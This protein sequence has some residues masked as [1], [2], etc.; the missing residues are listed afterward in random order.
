MRLRAG[1][2]HPRVGQIF[3]TGR[4]VQD[5]LPVTLPIG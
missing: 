4:S 2:H 1:V 3:L 5:Y